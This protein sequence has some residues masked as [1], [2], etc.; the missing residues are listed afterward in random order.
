MKPHLSHLFVDKAVQN[1][2]QQALKHNRE[3]S[4]FMS[5]A[6]KLSSSHN[7]DAKPVRLLL[8]SLLSDI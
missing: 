7:A 5:L 2:D 4:L 3:F 1:G 8:Q 6:I